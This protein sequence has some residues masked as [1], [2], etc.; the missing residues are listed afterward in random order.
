[1][2][3]GYLTA[4]LLKQK[5]IL[6]IVQNGFKIRTVA[7]NENTTIYQNPIE[8]IQFVATSECNLLLKFCKDKTL[9]YMLY[10]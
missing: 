7:K 1:L 8:K 2:E 9:F 5:I 10:G 3:D 6:Y 4:E